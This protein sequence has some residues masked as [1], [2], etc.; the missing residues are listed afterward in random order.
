MSDDSDDRTASLMTPAKLAQLKVRPAPA[1]SPS[2]YLDQM[3]S[4]A[5]AGHVRRLL[6]LRKNLEAQA[7][8]SG[9]KAAGEA[10]T[11]LGEAL[12]KL[13]FALVQPKGWL[14]RATGKGKEEGAAFV[15]QHDRVAR[16]A[17]DLADEAKSL[18]KKQQSQGAALERSLL[19]LDVEVRAIEKILDQG[20]RWLQ[21]MRNQIKTREAQGGD[22]AAQQ[23][24]RSDAA[25]C[26]LLVGRLKALR[27]VSGATQQATTHARAATAQRAALAQG[28][29]Q[30]V[31]TD[32]KS[33]RGQLAAIADQAAA[34]GFADEGVDAARHSQQALRTALQQLAQDCEA[35]QARDQ[36][37]A[38]EFAALQAPLQAAA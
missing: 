19:E 29:Q 16:A 6:D 10:C 23:Q 4:D 3:A 27:A 25:R 5:G 1:T 2:A 36:A 14:A 34:S 24:I 20:A 17:E 12:G 32:W 37:L 28:L 15:A 21:D 11:A 7:R 38:E 30:L 8:E 13:D 35:A 18:Q 26:E 33:G 9:A 22:A 31:D